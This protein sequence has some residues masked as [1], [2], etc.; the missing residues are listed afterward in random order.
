MNLYITSRK[1][2]HKCLTLKHIPKDWLDRTYLV[3]YEEEYYDYKDIHDKIVAVPFR[4]FGLSYKRQWLLENNMISNFFVLLDDD[5]RFVKKNPEDRTRLVKCEPEDISAMFGL[6]QSKL[7]E[8]YAHV[9]IS[10]RL[11]NNRFVGTAREATK[12]LHVLAYN[13]EILVKEEFRFDGFRFM[14]DYYM[15]L[16]LLTKGYRNYVTYEYAADAADSNAPGGCAVYR[17]AEGLEETAE[18]M[19]KTFPDFVEVELKW[20]DRAWK[21]VS[22]GGWRKD[23]KIQWKKAYDHGALVYGAKP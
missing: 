23:V 16:Q 15:T 12:M 21:G 1:R 10:P 6:I 8:G 19:A 4:P 20:T 9:G 2:A 18:G 7:E 14:S 5:L 13:R 22:E 17:T 3:V 11:M